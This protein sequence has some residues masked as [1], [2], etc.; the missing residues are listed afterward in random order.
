MSTAESKVIVERP[1]TGV[2]VIRINRP[3]VHNALS[4]SVRAE[5]AHHIVAFDADPDVRAI[6]ITGGDKVFAAGAD[7]VELRA[8]KLHD[9]AFRE[10]RVAWEALESCRMP[11]IAAVNGLALGGGCELALHCDIIIAGE[12]ANFA[13]TEVKLGIM[14]GAG[15]TQRFLR[16][17][18]KFVAM[19]YLLTGD[20]IPA[21]TALAMGLISEVVPDVE[22]LAHAL[23][24]ASKIAALPPLAIDAIKEAVILGADVP[25]EAGL[26]LERKSFQLLFGTEDRDEGIN[27]FL[28]K[29]K[30]SFKGR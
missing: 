1:L 29:R 4:M 3:E 16:A 28:E 25:L 7:L 2:A 10:S 8:R 12:G 20:F 15:G 6:V 21:R 14:P 17:T 22:V 18:G 24:L 26:V 9:K 5:M 19:R 30:P 11:V 27:A 13:Q 23:K